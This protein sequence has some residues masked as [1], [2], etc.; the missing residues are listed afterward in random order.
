MRWLRR[1]P[2]LRPAQTPKSI[3]SC[4]ARERCWPLRHEMQHPNSIGSGSS[5]G[6][7]THST[8]ADQG[9]VRLPQLCPHL[10][11]HIVGEQQALL[12]AEFF[13]TLLHGRLICDLAPLLDGL[14]SLEEIAAA[15]AGKPCRRRCSRR[16][17]FAV[18]QGVR[19]FG[20]S[21][22]GSLLGC[23]LGFARCVAALGRTAACGWVRQG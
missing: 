8:A 3:R 15:L 11:C 4:P 12:V 23:I 17:R 19:R 6:I 14:H 22:N 10:Q 7:L 5:T 21:R 20:G 1:L 2:K 9:L 16:D 18:G 13:N